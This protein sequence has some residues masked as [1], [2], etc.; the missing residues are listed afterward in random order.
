[1]LGGRFSKP[2]LVVATA[3]AGL[4]SFE[5][6]A[7]RLRRGPSISL[8]IQSRTTRNL[9][10]SPARA[11]ERA[12]IVSHPSYV[13]RKDAG[14]QRFTLQLVVPTWGF[15]TMSMHQR[16]AVAHSPSV[17]ID[18][19][20]TLSYPVVTNNAANQVHGFF[21]FLQIS[22]INIATHDGVKR[23]LLSQPKQS[24]LTYTPTESEYRPGKLPVNPFVFATPPHPPRPARRPN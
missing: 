3:T 1:M 7:L 23:S 12:P 9:N 10:L 8:L 5:P 20:S 19:K 24:C 16:M 21:S 17:W 14:G 6:P 2:G 22:N 15:E 4:Q 11:R 13:L 18:N